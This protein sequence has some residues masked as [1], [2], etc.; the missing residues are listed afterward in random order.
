MKETKLL[1][2]CLFLPQPQ[3][4]R[5]DTKK[6]RKPS[7]PRS[8]E[9][10][11]LLSTQRKFEKS[12]LANLF[13]LLPFQLAPWLRRSK[14]RR[15][16]LYPLSRLLLDPLAS[17]FPLTLFFATFPHANAR[18]KHNC[19]RGPPVSLLRSSRF[20]FVSSFIW[21]NLIHQRDPIWHPDRFLSSDFSFSLLS[22][23]SRVYLALWLLSSFSLSLFFALLSRVLLHPVRRRRQVFLPKPFQLTAPPLLSSIRSTELGARFLV[24][25][26]LNSFFL[27]TLSPPCNAS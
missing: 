20:P 22:A 24:V 23:V 11:R 9:P 26:C 18:T 1:R 17:S 5:K 13:A 19:S 10:G 15:F 21:P 16:V 2:G 14:E 4:S 25:D 8:R 7:L 27:Y 6:K 3:R 12:L